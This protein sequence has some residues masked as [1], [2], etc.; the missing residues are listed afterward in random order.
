MKVRESDR[1][2]DTGKIR[3][4][5]P[6]VRTAEFEGQ[7]VHSF[8]PCDMMSLSTKF[9]LPWYQEQDL[10]FKHPFSA[11]LIGPSGSGKTTFLTW[12]ISTYYKNF[13]EEKWIFSY[14]SK[15]DDLVKHLKIKDENIVSTDIVQGVEALFKRQQKEVED[16]GVS[17]SKKILCIFEDVSSN[18]K[19]LNSPWF[20]KAYTMNRHVNMSVILC[21]HKF[22]VVP[23]ICR[24]SSSYI[25]CWS[26]PLSDINQLIESLCPPRTNKKQF[27]DL[28][29]FAIQKTPDN[30]YPFLLCK[31]KK[32]FEERFWK[33]LD[34]LL[35]LK[36]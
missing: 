12:L 18:R 13:F 31:M 19:L 36:I 11:C 29:N 6:A 30:H 1:S 28:I 8:A 21:G 22:K 24:L 33:G 10:I 17:K 9:K 2:V 34:T 23:R 15:S 3:V 25:C 35:R 27:E 7:P 5:A 26:P 20:I 4:V 16:N 32:P 14:T